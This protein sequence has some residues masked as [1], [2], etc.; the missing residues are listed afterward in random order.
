VAT[1]LIRVLI[2]EDYEPFRRFVLSE[3]RKRSELQVIAEV[4]DGLVAVRKAEELQPDLVLVDIGLPAL[5]GIEVARQIREISLS[6]KILFVTENRSAD[7][8]EE[9]LKTGA[10]GYVVKSDAGNE[11]LLAV[12][13]V[14]EGKRFISAS[15]SDQFLVATNVATTLTA[16]QSSLI[17]L[18][19]GIL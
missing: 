19:S 11:L 15:L 10:G 14:L 13:A 12:Q 18:I 6:S 7:L 2:V 3:L 5:N 17:T 8:A 16:Q 4:S 9:A 1:S